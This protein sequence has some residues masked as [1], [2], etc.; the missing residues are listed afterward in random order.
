ML[1][2]KNYVYEVYKAGSFSKAAKN[3]FIS[4]PAL[5]TAVRKI[6]AQ[7]G[8]QL[9][10]RSSSPITLTE[11]GKAYIHALEQIMD[12]EYRLSNELLELSDLRS[13]H[14]N[15]GGANFFSSCML[16]PI[17]KI[18]TA[19]YPGIS[20]EITELDSLDLYRLALE[21]HIDL[22]ID[23]GQYDTD[24]FTSHHL[25]T[26]QVLL[27]VP[28]GHPFNEAHKSYRLTY[29]DIQNNRHLE[30]EGSI[31]LSKLSE[32]TFLF[33]SKGHDLYARG[34]E[35]CQDYGFIP[36]HVLYLNQLMTAY[37]LGTYGIG[38]VFVTDTLVKLANRQKELLYYPLKNPAAQCEI[39]LAHRKS[40]PMTKAMQKF[41]DIS[42]QVFS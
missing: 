23:S 37:N 22:I 40:S 7:V 39:F 24:L 8:N 4:Q 21:N 18:F 19:A 41:I 20:L 34:M 15:I 12:I 10:N 16:P 27:G 3:L 35:I 13:G 33:L 32:E 2:G 5:S 30:A 29:E 25:M 36:S 14:L 17:I 11:A 26:E 42:R 1:T 9:F 28:A 38:P 6:E 31:N